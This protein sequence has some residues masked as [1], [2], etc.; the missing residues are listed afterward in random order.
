MK[1]SE[2]IEFLHEKLELSWG[3]DYD[4]STLNLNYI[5]ELL[6]CKGMQPPQTH[7]KLFDTEG[8]SVEYY[9]YKWDKE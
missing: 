2:M 5:I 8:G 3:H 7:V 9:P 1:K 4:L 6:E